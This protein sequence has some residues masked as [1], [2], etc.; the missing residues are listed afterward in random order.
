VVLDIGCTFSILTKQFLSSNSHTFF[1]PGSPVELLRFEQPT[2]SLVVV[3]GDMRSQA[4]HMLRN[5]PLELGDGIYRF[6]FLVVPHSVFE[7]ALGLEFMDA[8]AA[9][10]STKVYGVPSSG[11]QLYIPTPRSFCRRSVQQY[12][13]AGKQCHHNKVAGHFTIT[14]MRYNAVQV[15]VSSLSA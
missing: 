10:V 2:P 14:P 9:R 6:N 11:P 4:I 3:L 13:P 15:A 7:V 5:V 8:Y 1:Y 12:W